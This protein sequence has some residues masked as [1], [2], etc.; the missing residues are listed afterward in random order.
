MPRGG[1]R[2]G[3]GRPHAGR[4]IAKTFRLSPAIAQYISEKPNQT[5][6]L[7]QT[8][9]FQSAKDS[10]GVCPIC[11]KPFHQCDYFKRLNDE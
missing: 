8:I 11:G 1:K 5:E 2:D 7:E 6:W 4:T 10:D 3:A 9:H